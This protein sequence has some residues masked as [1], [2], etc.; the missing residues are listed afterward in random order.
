MTK[1]IFQNSLKLLL[2]TTLRSNNLRN[3]AILLLQ[4][5]ENLSKLFSWGKEE[6]YYLRQIIYPK[7]KCKIQSIL[8]IYPKSKCKIQSILYQ[9]FSV[10]VFCIKERFPRSE[11]EEQNPYLLPIMLQS[12]Y[13]LEWNKPKNQLISVSSDLH[14]STSV[15]IFNTRR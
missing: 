7:S 9:D 3:K 6:N 15:L 13:V 10:T 4:C 11:R 12:T 8:Y 14:T 1:T 5:L 2:F